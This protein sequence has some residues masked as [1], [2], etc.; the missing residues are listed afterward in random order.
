M[1]KANV[2]WGTFAVAHTSCVSE[3]IYQSTKE[4]Q[5]PQDDPRENR[6]ASQA[7]LA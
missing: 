6:T 5:A 3:M 1:F 2:A 7:H 4:K